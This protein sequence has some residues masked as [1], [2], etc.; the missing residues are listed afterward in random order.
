MRDAVRAARPAE[1]NI[2]LVVGRETTR[3]HG[4]PDLVLS[5]STESLAQSWVDEADV[6]HFKGDTPPTPV[7]AGLIIPSATPSIVTVGGSLFRR[8]QVPPLR[9][10]DV[11]RRLR[12]GAATGPLS[13]MRRHYFR[14]AAFARFPGL[15][16][17]RLRVGVLPTGAVVRGKNGAVSVDL[18][19][20]RGDSPAAIRSPFIRHGGRP[21]RVGITANLIH[22]GPG[23]GAELFQVVVDHFREGQN[24][25]KDRLYIGLVPGQPLQT[26]R[27]V[28]ATTATSAIVS[29]VAPA[30][31]RANFS[32]EAFNIAVLK[33]GWEHPF[34]KLPADIAECVE[35]TS[36]GAWSMEAYRS[37]TIRSALTPDLVPDG[38]PF[39]YTPHA[40]PAELFSSTWRSRTRPLVVHAPT[41][42]RKKGTDSIILPALEHLRAKGIRFDLDMVED[43]PHPECVR[44]IGAATL[45]IDQAVTGWIGNAALEAMSM[46]V[47]VACYVS[48]NALEFAARGAARPPL[49]AAREQSV[50]SLSEALEPYLQKPEMLAALSTASREWVIAAHGTLAVGERMAALYTSLAVSKRS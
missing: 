31:T 32:V 42:R 21:L 11:R 49:I 35:S 20:S 25:R 41:D 15:V 2:R 44:R 29:I 5:S 27:L 38:E 4:N 10:A 22:S 18:R 9:E 45:F 17:G 43:V 28:R 19:R 40:F 36:R 13:R 34:G 23:G 8:L 33:A 37:A 24:V 46:G 6:I 14:D 30:T 12:V 16:R 50:A 7:Y 26:E 48:P 3:G 1:I 47:P 39:L